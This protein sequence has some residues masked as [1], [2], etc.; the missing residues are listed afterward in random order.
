[1]NHRILRVNVLIN[2]MATFGDLSIASWK[3]VFFIFI[4]MKEMQIYRRL[5]ENGKMATLSKTPSFHRQT[6]INHF[7]PHGMQQNICPNRRFLVEH[8]DYAHR[9][10]VIR[11]LKI[12]FLLRTLIKM[13]FWIQ[14]FLY[15]RKGYQ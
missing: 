8:A 15:G 12:L 4:A 7:I 11:H 3:R 10:L 1:M 5:K 9:Y 2:E 13:T 14:A 6:M